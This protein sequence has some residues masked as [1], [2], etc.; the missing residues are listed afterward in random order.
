MDNETKHDKVIRKRT[1][2]DDEGA[3]TVEDD[4]DDETSV[5]QLSP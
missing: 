4:D 5:A 1:G 2:N 3:A